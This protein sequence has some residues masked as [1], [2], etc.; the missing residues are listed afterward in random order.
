MSYIVQVQDDF[1]K[2]LCQEKGLSSERIFNET[3]EVLNLKD[4]PNN[5][6]LKLESQSS[7]ILCWRQNDYLYQFRPLSLSKG[8]LKARNLEQEFLLDALMRPET[9]MLTV[10]GEAGTGKTLL[11]VAAAIEMVFTRN[12]YE[13]LVIT[14]P[15]TQVTD[16][17]QSM[18]EVPG[19]MNEKMAPQMLSYEAAMR[20]VAGSNWKTFFDL[21][22]EKETLMI[23]PL[24][25]M[26]GIN[27]DNALVVCDEAQN[28]GLGQYKTLVTRMEDTSKLICMGD[29]RQVDRDH[30]G[31]P[32]L[33]SVANHRFYKESEITSF[34]ELLEV[35]RGPLVDLMIRICNDK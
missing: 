22:I 11:T 27:F 10:I 20:K 18:G 25:H 14:K 28:V 9:K 29:V 17:E 5:S 13:R 21:A 12:L 19:N 31:V 34:I 8:Q 1:I 6:Y 24:E 23:V 32:S 3:N 16:G 26:R 30:P 33:L 35:E 15:R 4:H 2:L 7:S